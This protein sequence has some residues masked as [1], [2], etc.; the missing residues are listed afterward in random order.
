MTILD[1][2]RHGEKRMQQ[3]GMSRQDID[4]VR[5]CGTQTEAGTWLML[6]RDVKRAVEA[7]KREIQAIERLEGWK[8][9]VIDGVL[10]TTYVSGSRDQK[11]TLRRSRGK[12]MYRPSGPRGREVRGMRPSRRRKRH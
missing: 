2:T 10:I 4:L 1:L 9:V 3:R 8:V 12:G 11:R 7:L 6:R 5:A